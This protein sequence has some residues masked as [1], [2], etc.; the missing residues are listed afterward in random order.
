[1][2]E[3][4]VPQFS[5]GVL[6]IEFSRWITDSVHRYSSRLLTGPGVLVNIKLARGCAPKDQWEFQDPKLE[7]LDHI[8]PYFLGISPY[9]G[10]KNRP[11]IW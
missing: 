6:T 7:V 8:R 9:I 10:L 3:S 11:Y 1:M 5:H 4:I 2:G